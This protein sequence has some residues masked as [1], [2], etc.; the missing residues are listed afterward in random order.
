MC[1][2]I[3]PLVVRCWDRAGFRVAMT[4]TTLELDAKFEV[5][6]KLKLVGHPDKIF[7]KTAFISGMFNS[8][9]E[10][11]NPMRIFLVC[12]IRKG[13]QHSYVFWH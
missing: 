1:A 2:R 6:K 10:V 11:R 9:L 12:P 7:K 4:G 3:T 13:R 5:V 8:D